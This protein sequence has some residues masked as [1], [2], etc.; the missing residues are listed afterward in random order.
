LLLAAVSRFTVAGSS[1]P[2]FQTDKGKHEWTFVASSSN[3]KD[4]LESKAAALEENLRVIIERVCVLQNRID[5]LKDYQQ[6]AR[7]IARDN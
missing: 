1:L 5:E 2:T 4:Q 7:H 6:A 3:E